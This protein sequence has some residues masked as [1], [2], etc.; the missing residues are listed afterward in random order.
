RPVL[1]PADDPALRPD[2][3]HRREQQEDEDD[4]DLEQH[5]PPGE[6][7]EA[8]ERRV[9]R[10]RRQ[11]VR[12]RPLKPH[13]GLLRVTIAP[14]PA[15][16]RAQMVDPAWTAGPVSPGCRV[17]PEYVAISAPFPGRPAA[18]SQTTWSAIGTTS[19]GT[20]TDPRSVATVTLSPSAAPAS[21]AVAA[22]IRATTGRA[23]PARAGSPSCIRP[24]SSNW[25]QVER[26]IAPGGRSPPDPP[27]PPDGGNSRRSPRQ[28]PSRP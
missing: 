25:C 5:Q 3:E 13:S 28:V 4:D 16:S 15:P 23:V 27:G 11:H 19:T 2:H 10:G 12:Q 7:V 24:L 22:D 6:L 21:A 26:N 8:G 17:S 20:V 1:H 14:C 18:G 9:G